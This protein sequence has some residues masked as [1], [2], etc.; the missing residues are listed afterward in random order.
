MKNLAGSDGWTRWL[1]VSHQANRSTAGAH[2]STVSVV[3]AG[4]CWWAGP[5]VYNFVPRC[6]TPEMSQEL[7]RQQNAQEL[8]EHRKWSKSTW[9]TSI[10]IALKLVTYSCGG[11]LPVP[12]T[13]FGRTVP[14]SICII[15]AKRLFGKYH[16]CWLS[17]YIHTLRP[18]TTGSTLI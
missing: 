7:P 15:G 8:N 16:W 10:E 11:G 5:S 13:A 9:P 4:T 6:K 12:S 18:A 2:H 17:P 3:T 14:V 1:N